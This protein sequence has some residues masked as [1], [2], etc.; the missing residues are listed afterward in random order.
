MTAQ[1]QL[2]C[3]TVWEEAYR[4]F[5]TPEEGVRKF[6]KRLRRL[7][8]DQWDKNLQIVE[9]FCGRGNGLKAIARLGFRRIEG[10]D[11]SESLLREYDGTCEK[12]YCSDCRQLPH[13]ANSRDVIIVHGG[14]HHLPSLPDDLYK[15]VDQA[16]RILRARG[17]MVLVEPWQTPFLRL[18]HFISENRLARRLWNKLDALAVMTEQERVTYEAW[19]RQPQMILECLNRYFQPIRIR[20]RRGK[21]LYLGEKRDK[22]S[23]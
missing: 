4:R 19:L 18:V 17:K 3:D 13:D 8:V 2:C 10:V 21:L 11:L 5:E 15:T 1:S 7:G 9:M 12:L 22:P 16:H 14:L 23:R 6:V 20:L